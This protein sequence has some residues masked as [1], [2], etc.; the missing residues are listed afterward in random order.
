MNSFF[1]LFPSGTV[2]TLRVKTGY[3]W[4][5]MMDSTNSL[6]PVLNDMNSASG[7]QAA[8]AASSFS[9]ETASASLQPMAYDDVFPGLPESTL[10]VQSDRTN[11][12]WNN[13]LRVG[14]R[15]VTQVNSNVKLSGVL[16]INFFFW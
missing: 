3:E 6:N 15:N 5:T 7:F 11:G 14:S 10:N 8:E 9:L 4:R 13:K 1:F 12:K 16:M 2:T